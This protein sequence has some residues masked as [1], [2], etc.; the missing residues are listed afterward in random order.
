MIFTKTQIC[1][2]KCDISCRNL[3]WQQSLIDLFGTLN[4]PSSFGHR[5]PEGI[6]PCTNSF[7][8][9][10]LNPVRHLRSWPFSRASSTN[11]TSPIAYCFFPLSFIIYPYLSVWLAA[12]YSP[13]VASLYKSWNSVPMSCHFS[14][15][16]I[17]WFFPFF[18]WLH[19]LE[20]RFCYKSI[21]LT[22]TIQS[23]QFRMRELTRNS[24][25]LEIQFTINSILKSSWSPSNS[26]SFVVRYG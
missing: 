3:I 11:H 18:R 14:L 15:R 17:D 21:Y 2:W 26:Q 16:S 19:H 1:C 23:I 25:I 6:Y 7:F 9:L 13:G 10:N 5:F 20:S 24:P 22:P 12:S 4:L 8:V